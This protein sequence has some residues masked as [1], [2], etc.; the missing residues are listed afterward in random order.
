MRRLIRA[1][2]AFVAKQALDHRGTAGSVMPERLVSC[3]EGTMTANPTESSSAAHSDDD[4]TEPVHW[5]IG[6]TKL[7]SEICAADIPCGLSAYD[8][9]ID[10]QPE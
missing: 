3:H 8:I 4:A 10:Y 6:R 7:L 5:G 9:A 1:L 2:T